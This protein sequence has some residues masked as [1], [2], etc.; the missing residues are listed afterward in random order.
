MRLSKTRIHNILTYHIEFIEAILEL[1]ENFKPNHLSE[2]EAMILLYK[3]LGIKE[4]EWDI[5]LDNLNNY[6][7]QLLYEDYSYK[8]AHLKLSH[9]FSTDDDIQR[10]R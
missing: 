5:Y 1:L 4:S 8:P 6:S 10:I 2:V 9:R 7:L 3:F